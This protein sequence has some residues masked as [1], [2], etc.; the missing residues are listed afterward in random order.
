MRKTVSLLA[1]LILYSVL[2]VAQTKLVT[3]LVMDEKGEPIPFASVKIKGSSTGVAADQDGKFSISVD[4]KASLII[5]AAGFENQEVSVGSQTEIN[6]ALKT[7]ASLQEVV[8]TA[9]GIKRTEKALGYSVSKVDPNSILQ[10]SEPDVL[11]SLQGK[12]P[13]VD[14]RSSQGTPGAATRIQIRGNT[15]FFGQNE[16]LIIVDGVPYSNNSLTSSN[17]VN[18][19]G[20]Y[21]SGI[22]NLDPNDIASMNVLKGSSAAALYGSRA[23]NGA[24]IIT[25]KSGNASRSKKGLEVTY[26]TSYSVENVANLPEYQNSYG[27]GSQ[28]NAGGGSNGSWG[29]KFGTID[30]VATWAPYASLI[31]PKVAYRAYPDNVKSLFRTG[32]VIENSIS[33]NGGNEKSSLAITASQLNQK[34]YVT[35]ADYKRTN[36][37]LGGTTRLDMG[38]NISGNFSYTRSNQSGGI[39][40]ENQVDFGSQFA[41]TLFLGRSWNLDLPFEDEQGNN[42]T[43]IAGQFDN[44]KWSAKYNKSLTADERYIAGLHADYSFNSWLKVD[45]RIGTNVST[46]N[47]R[48]VTEISSTTASAEGLG[49]LILDNSRRQEI[50]SNLFFTINPKINDDF[51]INVILGQNTNQRTYT[52][53]ASTGKR[54]ITRGI[55]TLDNTSQQIFGI[56]QSLTNTYNFGDYYS[57]QRLIGVYGRA[58]FGYKNFA[59]IEVT[60]RNDWSSTLPIESRSYFY[61]SVSGSFVFSDAFKLSNSFFDY[62]KI[63]A[64]W[65]KVGRDAD[66]Y[67]LSDVFVLGSNFLGQPTA[68]RSSTSPDPN[69]KPEFTNEYEIGTNLSFFKRRIEVDFTYYNRFS[70]N[71]IA[72]IIV[73]VTSGYDE[74]YTNFGKITNEGLEIGLSV[75]PLKSREFSWNVYGAFTKNKNMVTELTEGVERL[76]LRG[77]LSGSSSINPYLEPGM[78]FG[79]LRGDVSARDS[80]T[81]QLLIDPTSGNPITSKELGYLGNPN[82]DFKLGITNTFTYKGFFASVLFDMT[83]GGAIYSVTTSSLLG[84]GVTKDTEDRETGWVIPGI[85]GDP[86]TEKAILV[87]GKTVPNQTRMTTNDLYFSNGG[88]G[89]FAINSATEWNVYDATVY[90]IREVGIGFNFPKS[91]LDKLPFGSATITV[92]GRNLWY[93]APNFPKYTN[94]D[95]EVNSLGSGST[96]GIE[97]SA[98]PTTKRFGINLKVTF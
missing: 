83:K 77:V 31:G 51:S 44:P 39:F 7:T 52:R 12:V 25:T 40:G 89:T 62:G 78:P 33:V 14:I 11:K 9:L 74:Y 94:F 29:A 32:N 58:E 10:K 76:L 93:L 98:A 71:L 79:Y 18:G 41:R 69:L 53:N 73:P 26:S 6:V 36:I 4:S 81:G 28:L 86:E 38:I 66:P 90:R 61:P 8:V 96:Q 95:P 55:Y 17:Q 60:G 82:P 20:A 27:T 43:F 57:R 23:S 16:P 22:A 92:T 45:Y 46:V 50:E 56:D 21:S 24:I 75:T 49:R 47:R 15:S 68:S 2:A 54:F 48:E 3:G 72:P 88:G 84:R 91:L 97:L 30:S 67:Y 37:S 64:S 87:G 65:S 13:G 34:G 80:A 42:L 35:N 19:G 5:S 70:T 59:F 85:Y 63:R 1:V